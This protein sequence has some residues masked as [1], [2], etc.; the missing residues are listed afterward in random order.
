MYFSSS[1]HESSSLSLS[2]SPDKWVGH[3]PDSLHTRFSSWARWC[4]RGKGKPTKMREREVPYDVRLRQEGEG[5]LEKKMRRTPSVS[6]LRRGRG[7]RSRGIQC[8]TRPACSSRRHVRVDGVRVH[9]PRERKTSDVWDKGGS[10]GVRVHVDFEGMHGDGEMGEGRERDGE[11][12]GGKR[13]SL[14]TRSWVRERD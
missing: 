10:D 1:S 6:R 11:T 3:V 7:W 12:G 5:A 4:K 13:E 2:L 9:V 14:E 8:V